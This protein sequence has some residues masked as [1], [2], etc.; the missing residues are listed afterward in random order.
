MSISI[1][2]PINITGATPRSPSGIAPQIVWP[3]MKV[4]DREYVEA[5]LDRFPDEDMFRE[6]RK[7]GIGGAM[8]PA[9][10]QAVRVA[11]ERVWL[12]DEYLLDCDRCGAQLG[13][14]FLKTGAP[15]IRVVSVSREGAAERAT[16]LRGLEQDL[17]KQ[18]AGGIPP[19][20]QIRLNS[21]NDQPRDLPEM[22]DRFAIIDDVLWHC[23]ATI[24]GLHQAINAM[25]FGWSAN[26]TNAIPF[27][28][29]LWRAM[30]DDN[31]RSR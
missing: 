14:L 10:R 31:A 29:R 1:A 6:R 11:R 22:H 3:T 2:S 24:G 26:E 5:D 27:F 15:D 9:F 25:S 18:T 12:V 23:G 20:I 30:E 7:R 13:E 16:K 19:R 4:G 28:E 17:Q 8:S 21:R